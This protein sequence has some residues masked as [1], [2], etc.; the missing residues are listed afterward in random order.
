MN[1]N[2]LICK[3]IFVVIM[4]AVI[5]IAGIGIQGIEAAAFTNSYGVLLGVT[6]DKISK[7]SNYK[8]IIIDASEYKA[9]DIK[10]LKKAGH[11]VYS[12][13]NIGSVETYRSYYKKF[14]KHTLGSYDNWPDEYWMDVSYTTWQKYIVNTQAKSIYKKGIDGFFI[15]NCDVYYNFKK[16]KIYNGLLNILKNLRKSYG[17]PVIVNGGD[18]FVTKVLKSGNSYK[19]KKIINAVNQECVYSSIKDYTKNVFGTAS[20]SSRNYFIS[21]LKSCK[22]KGLS[23]YLTEYTKDAKLKKSIASFCK[24]MGYKY[25][26]SSTVG[27]TG[28]K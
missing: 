1:N 28:D 17:L 9:S 2:K 27:L 14:K 21:Y 13:L 6:R 20:K 26:I 16:N 12:Y 8:T 25:Y 11:T 23:V 5:I 18:T 4:T 22:K 19:G 3:K 7:L 15:D 10:K 24:K